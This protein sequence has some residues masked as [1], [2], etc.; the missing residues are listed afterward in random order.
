MQRMFV[1]EAKSVLSS[2]IVIFEYGD[3]HFGDFML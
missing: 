1:K 3:L 2:D